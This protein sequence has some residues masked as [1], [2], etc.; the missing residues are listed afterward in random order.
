MKKVHATY[1][2]K[3]NSCAKFIFIELFLCVFLI[4]IKY[5]LELSLDNGSFFVV[6]KKKMLKA[7]ADGEGILKLHERLYVNRSILVELSHIYTA[8]FHLFFST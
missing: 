4:L 3:V 5:K 8:Y 1:N 2:K 6:K 7:S